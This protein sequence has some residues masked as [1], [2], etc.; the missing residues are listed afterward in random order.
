MT[1]ERKWI[2]AA[3]I[4]V[5]PET[6]AILVTGIEGGYEVVG[7]KNAEGTR[8]NPATQDTLAAVLA[9]LSADPATQ[10]TLAAALTALNTLNGGSQTFARK[11]LSAASGTQ[12]IVAATPGKTA[13]VMGLN[14]VV[15]TAQATVTIKDSDG[16]TLV[17]LG[18]FAV[19]DG[20]V[21]DNVAMAKLAHA[22]AALGKG[23]SIVASA[24]DL[25][26]QVLYSLE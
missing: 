8:V 4:A 14:I 20:I 19:G 2:Q 13:R 6:G 12:V 7:L 23:L 25:T 1:T 11:Q 22:E 10:T 3:T 17:V 21:L 16:A 5:D 18:T 15:G 9:K 24:G 26:G